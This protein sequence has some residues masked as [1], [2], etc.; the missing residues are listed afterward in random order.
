MD[1]STKYIIK[2]DSKSTKK[3]WLQLCSKEIYNRDLNDFIFGQNKRNIE[4]NHYSFNQFKQTI[5]LNNLDFIFQNKSTIKPE[6]KF[7]DDMLKG[8]FFE[9]KESAEKALSFMDNIP[10]NIKIISLDRLN[11]VIKYRI[12]PDLTIEEFIKYKDDRDNNPESNNFDFKKYVFNTHLFEQHRYYLYD[13][14]EEAQKQL[15]I[16]LIKYLEENEEKINLAQN[17]IDQISEKDLA[18]LENEYKTFIKN[19]ILKKLDLT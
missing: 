6:F 2:D 4:L 18:Q 19:R 15:N 3:P 5:T 10:E 14:K 11:F 13:Y 16:F 9:N 7:T 8:S 12:T 1:I 17:L